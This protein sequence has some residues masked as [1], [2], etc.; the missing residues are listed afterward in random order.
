M[1]CTPAPVLRRNQSCFVAMT[2]A[3]WLL[4][5]EQQAVEVWPATSLDAAPLFPG[6]RSISAPSG[7]RACSGR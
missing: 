3:T 7:S 2:L 5:P 6:C 4:I 1:R